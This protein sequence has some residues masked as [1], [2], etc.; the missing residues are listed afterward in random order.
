MVKV[1]VIVPVYNCETYLEQCIRSVLAQSLVELEIICVDD[2]STDASAQVIQSLAAEDRRIVSFWQENQGAGPARNLG[3]RKARGKYV[4]FLDADDY[5]K[6]RD[7]LMVM[8]HTC[9]CHNVS[10]CASSRMCVISQEGQVIERKL[11]AEDSVDRI[12]NYRDYQIDYSYQAYL[13]QREMLV[14]NNIYFPEYRRYQDPPF[15][16]RAAYAGDKFMAV[17]TCLYCYRQSDVDSKYDT[18][19]TVDL[20]RGV[21]DNLLFADRCH[22]DIL[23]HNTAGRLE[24]TFLH[25]IYKNISPNDLEILK[26][27]LQANQIICDKYG[28]QKYIIKPLRLILFSAERYERELL[29]KM[30]VEEE[31]ALYGA[32]RFAK[33]FLRYLKNNNLLKKVKTIIVTD[34]AGN[35]SELEGIPVTSFQ[36]F[37]RMKGCFVFVCVAAKA[38]QEIAENLKQNRYDNYGVIN[39]IFGEQLLQN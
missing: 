12:L 20:L 27:L 1:S 2:G 19:K 16:V 22:L 30:K 33:A 38:A 28:R 10:V 9:E 4:C 31:I 7:A 29:Q 35:A 25:I 37:L 32:G 14:D 11:F 6:D 5:Y 18:K 3:I 34:V 23:F 21:I 8:F 15:L 13:F 26:L 17:D 24:N 39:E 36:E